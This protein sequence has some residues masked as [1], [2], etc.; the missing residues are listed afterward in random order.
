[1][2]TYYKDNL[3]LPLF[4]TEALEG[5]I[6]LGKKKSE[7][8]YNKKDF[9]LFRTLMVQALALLDRIHHYESI[10]RNFEATQKKLYDTERLLARSERIASMTRL[11]QEYNHEIRTPLTIIQGETNFLT[12]EPRDAAYLK[13]FQELVLKHVSRAID[14]VESTVRLSHPKERQEIKLDLNDV[15][16]G[17]LKMFPP[18]GVHLVKELASIPPIMGDKEDLETAFTNLI[19]NA[20]EAMPGGGDLKIRTYPDVESEKPV[21]CAEIS[22][23]GIGIPEENLGKIFE[24]FFSTHVTKGR[25][26]G[27]SIVFRIIREHL[28]K[29]EVKSQAGKG[30][31]FKIQFTAS[32]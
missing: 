29:I 21:V 12:K 19:K 7:D 13:W 4:S 27:L 16:N 5:I 24:P 20:V 14:I 28:G 26:L 1:D 23:T 22:D 9:T 10:K 15:I 2:V 8:T 18:S 6:V 3:Y 32:K 30:A 25:G 31:T 11:L 17:A